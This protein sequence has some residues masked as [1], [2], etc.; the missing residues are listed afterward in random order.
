MSANLLHEK[1]YTEEEAQQILGLCR[2][3]L[4][5]E[6]RAGRLQYYRFGRNVEYAESHL[7][8]YLRLCARNV[9]RAGSEGGGHD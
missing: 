8:N 7:E 5:N 9:A 3:T 2:A 6:R 1:R 4:Y